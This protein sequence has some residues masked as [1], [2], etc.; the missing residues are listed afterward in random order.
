M[1]HGLRG[2]AK[3]NRATKTGRA[4]RS[5]AIAT[6]AG[7]LSDG[8]GFERERPAADDA[9]NTTPKTVPTVISDRDLDKVSGGSAYV[10]YAGKNRSYHSDDNGN[11]HNV[12]YHIV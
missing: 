3:A 10:H 12:I 4:R 5:P 7:S 11:V 9:K 8:K 6:N 2:R 1:L